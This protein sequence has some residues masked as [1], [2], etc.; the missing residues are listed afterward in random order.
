M[1]AAYRVMPKKVFYQDYQPEGLDKAFRPGKRVPTF[2]SISLHTEGLLK[3][4]T[5]EPPELTDVLYA[6]ASDASC[7]RHGQSRKDFW[8]ELGFDDL[9]KG[10]DA[11]EGCLKTWRGLGDLDFNLDEL[12]EIFQDY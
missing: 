9:E 8:D 10:L 5:P 7:V 1:G 6:L 3:L 2:G 4:S 11:W 12:D